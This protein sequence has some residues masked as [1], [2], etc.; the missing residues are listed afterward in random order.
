MYPVYPCINVY[1][2][3]ITAQDMVKVQ[4]HHFTSAHIVTFICNRLEEK[5]S[6]VGNYP[7]INIH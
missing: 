3:C 5:A 6:H 7:D 1:I 4:F 2:H